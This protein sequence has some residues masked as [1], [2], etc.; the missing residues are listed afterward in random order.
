MG[1]E[2][3]SKTMV[4]GILESLNMIRGMVKGLK[5][6]MMAET[7]QVNTLMVSKKVLEKLNGLVVI[8]MKDNS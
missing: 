4:R 5:N 6:G 7:L 3:S 8:H 1:S 2:E